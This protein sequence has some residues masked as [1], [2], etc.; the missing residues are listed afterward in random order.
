MEACTFDAMQM[1]PN[2]LPLIDVDKCT[3]CGDCVRACPKGIIE[4]Y[5]INQHLIVQCKSLLAG[6]EALATC[7]VACTGCG[8]CAA[9]APEGLIT[10]KNNLP[11][12]NQNLLQLETKIATLRC[13]TGA[14]TWVEEQQFPEIFIQLKKEKVVQ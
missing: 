8:I 14:I 9:D 5:P 4:L 12:I 10:M 13:P 1:A 3:G 7:D 11:V 2:G 6:D